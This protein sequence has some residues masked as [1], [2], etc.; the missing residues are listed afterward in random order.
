M[1]R[2]W[3]EAR[4]FQTVQYAVVKANSKYGPKDPMGT[5]YHMG[6]LI[7]WNGEYLRKHFSFGDID[8]AELRGKRC[9]YCNDDW[10]LGPKQLPPFPG[11]VAR[12]CLSCPPK[13]QTFPVD[14]WISVGFGSAYVSCDGEAVLYDESYAMDS[15]A[16]PPR[17]SDAEALAA[18][19][20]DHDWRIC[21][22]GPMGGQE[23][24]RH[25]VGEWVYV[26][27][28]PGFA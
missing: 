16:E 9:G 27:R 3:T 22:H 15:D 12:H 21:L 18:E 10:D 11:A 1:S 26:K 24:Q 2:P 17:G 23:Y 14:G 6:C 20:P 19:D 13:P 5:P 8:P 4:Q 25:G 28:I 7:E